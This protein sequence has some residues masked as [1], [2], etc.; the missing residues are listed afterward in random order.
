MR[1]R[2]WVGAMVR[3]HQGK[4]SPRLGPRPL[5][6]SH[7]SQCGHMAADAVHLEHA[8]SATWPTLLDRAAISLGVEHVLWQSDS[9]SCYRPRAPEFLATPNPRQ[10]AQQGGRLRIKKPCTGTYLGYN[11]QQHAVATRDRKAPLTGRTVGCCHQLPRTPQRCPARSSVTLP[12][13]HLQSSTRTTSRCARHTD[14]SKAIGPLSPT[15]AL[16]RQSNSHRSSAQNPTAGSSEGSADP[17]TTHVRDTCVWQARLDHVGI[18]KRS[19]SDASTAC[20][21]HD[22]TTHN[23]LTYR[24]TDRPTD[25]PHNDTVTLSV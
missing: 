6:D 14:C 11:I 22:I 18:E 12:A 17:C 3:P 21:A 15:C 10:R 25:P 9:T 24:P 4:C 1:R 8:G 23:S 2:A 7:R 13:L 5:P 20:R 19:H 16:S